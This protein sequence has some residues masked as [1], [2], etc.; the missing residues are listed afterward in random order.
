MPPLLSAIQVRERIN[1]VHCEYTF[2]N[3]EKEYNGNTSPITAICNKHGKFITNLNRITGNKSRCPVCGNDSRKELKR[4]ATDSIL[5]KLKNTNYTFPY[6][7]N[8][9]IDQFSKITA[10]CSMHGEFTTHYARLIHCNA[11]CPACGEISRI[12]KRRN[13][14]VQSGL[15]DYDSFHNKLPITD[16][17]I[18]G[19]YGELKVRCKM[20]QQIM[21]PTLSQV[22]NRIWVINNINLG[23]QNFYCSDKCKTECSVYHKQGKSL[24]N[25][26]HEA[27]VKLARNCQLETKRVLRQHQMDQYGYHFCEKCSKV[28]DNPE[29]HHTIEVA[30]DPS[31]AITIAGQM[32]VCNECHK[33]FTRMCR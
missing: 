29:L 32:L 25:S 19:D 23:E 6:F 10:V 28:V 9:Y 7:D 33:E 27:K 4:K 2:P 11:G 1:S 26:D 8:E 5:D 22:N 14:A 15:A 18:R 21:T 12:I 13:V 31:G 3:I 24:L 20:C 30:K 16:G 17:A